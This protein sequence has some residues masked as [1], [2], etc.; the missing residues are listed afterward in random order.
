MNIQTIL[1][2]LF[3]SKEEYAD[4]YQ[5]LQFK[6]ELGSAVIFLGNRAFSDAK[7]FLGVE[8]LSELSYGELQN[9]RSEYSELKKKK[10]IKIID[11][12][13]TQPRNGFGTRVLKYI[14]ELGEKYS[15]ND[16]YVNMPSAQ[17]REVLGA[18]IRKGYID[19]DVNSERGVSIDRY[20]THFYLKG[21][22]E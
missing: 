14:F 22:P 5:M 4:D 12:H 13:S 21:K 1:D 18:F 2:P 3:E 6:N 16:F 19:P 10:E 9:F 20:P 11:W 15:I 8:D 17:A 7:R